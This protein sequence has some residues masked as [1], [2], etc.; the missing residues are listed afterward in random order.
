MSYFINIKEEGKIIEL[1]PGIYKVK[2]IG[3][4][5]VDVGNFSLSIQD[6]DTNN[7]IKWRRSELGAFS[8]VK[9]MDAKIIGTIDIPS[10]TNYSVHFENTQDLAIYRMGIFGRFLFK[11]FAKRTSNLIIAVG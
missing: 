4:W 6:I 9:G 10:W 1:Q 7:I 5:F 11:R 2:L 3:S 8:K